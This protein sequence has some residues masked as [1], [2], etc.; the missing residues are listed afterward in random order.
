MQTTNPLMQKER[1]FKWYKCN[2]SHKT[3]MFTMKHSIVLES[4]RD[5]NLAFFFPLLLYS[6]FM[7]NP[8]H[9]T[10]HLGAKLENTQEFQFKRAWDFNNRLGKGTRW[11]N[12][13][14]RVHDIYIFMLA[15]DVKLLPAID[16]KLFLTLKII[17]FLGS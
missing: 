7:S 3:C 6:L 12:S 2:T 1:G 9:K 11:L 14:V 5:K 15:V 8:P 13:E 10:C 4:T 16:V 17:R